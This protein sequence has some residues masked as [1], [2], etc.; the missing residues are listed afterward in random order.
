MRQVRYV[1]G[2]TLRIVQPNISQS[3]KWRDENMRVI[4]DQLLEMSARAPQ[5][6]K[7]VTHIIWPES[8]VPFLIDESDSSRA[9][10]A[11]LLG[12]SQN[13]CDRCPAARIQQFPGEPTRSTTAFSRLSM[14]SGRRGGALRQVAAGSRGE[15]LPIEWLLEP[16][17]ISQSGHGSGKFRGGSRTREPCNSGG[18]V[19]LDFRSA[20]RAFSPITSLIRKSGRDGSLMSPVTAGLELNRTLTSTWRRRGCGLSSRDCPWSGWQILEFPPLLTLMA[21]P[22]RAC[23]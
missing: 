12:G 20:I 6:G 10:L 17:G 7:P 18:L 16:L 3:D 13:S 21:G 15:F 22:F 8:A 23:L 11:Q 19:L 1:D 14:A 4:F 9:E 2:V 5:N